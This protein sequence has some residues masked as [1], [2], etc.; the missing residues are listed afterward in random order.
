MHPEVPISFSLAIGLDYSNYNVVVVRGLPVLN[1]TS[2]L[3]FQPKPV[4]ICTP[5]KRGASKN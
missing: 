5:G 4:P 1:T 3:P 2:L